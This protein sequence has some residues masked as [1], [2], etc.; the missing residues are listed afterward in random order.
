MNE[1][2]EYQVLSGH[3]G[4]GSVAA[5]NVLTKLDQA[6]AQGW[7]AV[8]MTRDDVGGWFNVLMKRRKSN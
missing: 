1:K 7:E 4:D 6:G 8:S 5:H 3:L 2:W